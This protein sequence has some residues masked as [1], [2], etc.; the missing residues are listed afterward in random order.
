MRSKIIGALL[1]FR[2]FFFS[3]NQILNCCSFIS[4]NESLLFEYMQTAL[5]GVLV[6][7][8]DELVVV[9]AQLKL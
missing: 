5:N 1:Q 3:M 8:K 7:G 6:F 2:W 9:A 4:L